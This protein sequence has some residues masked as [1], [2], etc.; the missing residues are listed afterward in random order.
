MI[1]GLSSYAL[2]TLAL[3]IACFGWLATGI[4]TGTREVEVYAQKPAA[5]LVKLVGLLILYA[6]LY[7]PDWFGLRP[8]A[9]PTVIFGSIGI[10]LCAAGV[11][12]VVQSR[13]ALGRNWSDLVVVKAKREIVEKGPYR[14]LRHPLYSGCMLGFLGSAMTI[15]SPLAYGIAAFCAL[16]FVVKARKEEALLAACF[17][18]AYPAYRR[19]VKAFVPFLL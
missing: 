3:W 6:L 16:G 8:P 9:A 11:A 10:V 12:L 18:T 19:Q 2:V 17:P 5:R 15:G 14:W 1:I 7:F 13:R 4:G